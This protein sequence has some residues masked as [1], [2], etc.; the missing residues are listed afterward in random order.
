[1]TERVRC[2]LELRELVLTCPSRANGAHL[3]AHAFMEYAC[4]ESK[5][6]RGGA[7]C[8]NAAT[9]GVSHQCPAKSPR[10]QDPTRE[11]KHEKQRWIGARSL[12]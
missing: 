7:L 5:P 3:T 10:W 2:P 9:A 4:I 8:G 6:V 12:P 1:M 11:G